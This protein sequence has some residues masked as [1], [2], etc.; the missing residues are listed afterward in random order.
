M[1]LSVN[2][3]LRVAQEV[4]DRLS[5][6]RH[7]APVLPAGVGDWATDGPEP[8]LEHPVS[9]LCTARQLEEPQFQYWCEQVKAPPNKHR[10]LW[11]FT[12]ILEVLRQNDMLRAGRKGLGFG[13]GEEPLAAVMA[14]RGVEVLATDLDPRQR[15][16]RDWIGTNQHAARIQDLNRRGICDPERF[17]ELVRF[18]PADM[19]AIPPEFKGFDFCWSSCALEHLGSINAGLRFVENT[20]DC[21]KPGGLL[22]HTTEFNCS[23]DGRTVSH[24]PT[25][26]FRMKDMLRLGTA[27]REKGHEVHFNFNQGQGELDRHV[28]VPPYTSDVHLKLRLIRFV[29]T[30]IGLIVR[31]K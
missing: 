21:V 27:L 3:A 7:A 18:Q 15:A 4:R 12:F 9:Q 16:A 20:L 22:V 14:S 26:I 19:N 8:S 24:G 29:S 1:D 2:M 28:D 5:P 17:A 30:S 10:K 23:S 6:P 31:R 25:V 13:V 11:E